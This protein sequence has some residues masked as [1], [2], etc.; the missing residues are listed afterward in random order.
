MTLKSKEKVTEDQNLDVNQLND[1][2]LKCSSLNT[3]EASVPL[4]LFNEDSVL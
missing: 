2:I 4:K 3:Q 1:Y